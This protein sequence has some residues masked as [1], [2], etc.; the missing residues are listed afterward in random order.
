MASG[1]RLTDSLI[2]LSVPL[3]MSA[4]KDDFVVANRQPLSLK[5]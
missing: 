2:E 5:H 4:A 3:T 1:D